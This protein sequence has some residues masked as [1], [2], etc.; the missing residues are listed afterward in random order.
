MTTGARDLPYH[1]PPQ[2]FR[3][4]GGLR[5]EELPGPRVSE[6]FTGRYLGRAM[7]RLDWDR[8]GAED[9]AITHLEQPAALLTNTT[10]VRGHFLTFRLHATDTSRNAI[11]AVVTMEAGEQK[12]VRHL[13]AGD[14]YHASNEPLLVFGLGA[15]T[16][17]DRVDVLWPI[18]SPGSVSGSGSGQR[19]STQGKATIRPGPAFDRVDYTVTRMF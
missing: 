19:I 8:D 11:G 15:C 3:N 10:P 14:G 13:T 17:I 5:F 2:Y 12:R 6:Y 7:A 9:L 16:V 4:V 18:R 1:M